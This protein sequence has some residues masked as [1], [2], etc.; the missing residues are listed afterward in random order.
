MKRLLVLIGLALGFMS[1]AHAEDDPASLAGKW[2]SQNDF[3]PGPSGEL[4]LEVVGEG[5]LAHHGIVEGEVINA[6]D[7]RVAVIFADSGSRFDG[8]IDIAQGRM[9]GWWTQPPGPAGMA[10][11]TP[12]TLIH[13]GSGVW[14]GTVQPLPQTFTLEMSVFQHDGSWRAAFRNR[15]YNLNGGSPHF[16][17]A[18]NGSALAFAATRGD[19]T[20][21]ATVSPDASSIELEWSPLPQPLV[22]TRVET[23]ET[24]SDPL[25]YEVPAQ[26]DDG[27]E[28]G[29]AKDEGFDETALDALVRQIAGADPFSENPQRIHSL[30]VIRNGR[31]VLDAYFDGHDASTPHDLRS[32]GKTLT[33]IL[34]GA[35]MHSGA[36]IG[37]DTKPFTLLS[38]NGAP[39]DPAHDQITLGHLMTHT[40]GLACDDNDDTSQGNEGAM[41]SQGDEPDWWAYTLRLPVLH[42][43][44]ARYAYCTAGMNLVGAAM[45]KISGEAL[46]ALFQ[47]LVAGPLRFGTYHW[48]L[49]PSGEAYL[50]GGMHMRPRD[51]AK[52]GQLYLNGGIW[53]GQR[54]VSSDWV[55]TS[56]S[57]QV[58]INEETTGMD[59]ERFAQIATR[60]ADGYAWHL[61]GVTSAGRTY[62]SYEANGN[63]G[64]Y[65]VVVPELEL[66]V[67][68]TGG[69]YGQGWIWTKWRNAVIGNRIIGALGTD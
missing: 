6:G 67:V 1:P 25:S 5:W 16:T 64:Q 28:T 13:N 38:G 43:P 24:S 59:A 41:Q 31:L 11:A 39:A 29:R 66:V 8:T 2:I 12:V 14:R 21:N 50:G 49:M 46:P 51:L 54:I 69:N 57:R 33:S 55:A 68:I 52:L 48:N 4:V 34:L 56:T 47:R 45:R 23:G 61:Y 42:P 7:A 26:L 10:F 44:G 22:L 65:L 37:P 9:D 19:S 27:W 18:R 62:A 35:M 32:A 40:S 36:E 63:G 20:R 15:E 60:G 58:E 30:L 17:I 3:G 53:H